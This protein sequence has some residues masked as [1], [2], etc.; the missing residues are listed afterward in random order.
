MRHLVSLIVCAAIVV[1]GPVT[2][3]ASDP[4]PGATAGSVDLGDPD[5][6]IANALTTMFTWSPASDASPE[7][8]YRRAAPY[9]SGDLAK[10]GEQMTVPG[11]GSQWQQWRSAGAEVTAKVYFLADETPPNSDEV[12]HRVIVVVQSAATG[13]NRLIDE[14]R[15]TAWVTAN[16]SD[17]SWRVTTIKF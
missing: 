11:P 12:A 3:C 4:L 2:G 14:I 13:D 6:V 7:A 5:V 1:G 15:H 8:A 16:K 9:L 17:N 10:Q